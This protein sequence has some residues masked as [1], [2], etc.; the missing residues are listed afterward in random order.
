MCGMVAPILFVSALAIFG[1]LREGYSHMEHEISE[2]G[3]IGS[4]N[5][6][7]VNTALILTGLLIL[8]FS[9]GL[10]RGTGPGKRVKLGSLLV[11][12]I[13]L[14]IAVSGV[15]P[16][17]PHC[18]SPGCNSVATTGH[19]VGGFMVFPLIP[20]AILLFARGL[21]RDMAWGHYRT[22]SLVTSIVAFAILVLYVGIESIPEHW[23]GAVQRLYLVSW[24]QWIGVMA[25]RL[26]TL[27]GPSGYRI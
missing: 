11:S 7:G 25:I 1:L 19:D 10:Y 9:S 3:A 15:S 8:A 27:S 24:F 23:K 26:F 14:G 18:P 12:V 17:D 4:P 20:F 21:G 2:L 16:Y 22:Y 13:G 5:M 6:E